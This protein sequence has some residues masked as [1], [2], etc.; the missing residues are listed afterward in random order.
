MDAITQAQRNETVMTRAAYERHKW[1]R[2]D[3]A[4]FLNDRNERVLAWA[5]RKLPSPPVHAKQMGFWL[6]EKATTVFDRAHARL[7]AL[8]SDQ[9]REA[10]FI[11]D[12]LR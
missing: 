2:T 4:R 5:R 7:A 10:T 1:S 6:K 8:T 11:E 9:T 3:T 12:L